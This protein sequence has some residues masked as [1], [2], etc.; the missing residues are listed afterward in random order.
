LSDIAITTTTN[1][2]IPIEKGLDFILNHFSGNMLWPKTISTKATQGRQIIVNSRE[3]ALAYFKAANFFDCRISA[4]PYW[5]PSVVS[6]FVSVKNSIVPDLIM[7]DLDISNFDYDYKALKAALQKILKRIKDLLDL[8]TPIVIWSGN[9]YHIYILID[10]PVVLEDIKEFADIQQPSTKFLRFAEWYL[11]GGLSDFAHNSTVSLNNCMLRIPGSYN[12]KN[13]Q[14]VRIV[15]EWN[16]NYKP[17]ISLLLGSFCTYLKDQKI[18]EKMQKEV[19]SRRQ[20]QH[21]HQ[22]DASSIS[23]IETLLQNAICEG[24][25]MCIWHI[26]APYL[27]NVK[28]K[29]YQESF[30]VIKCW[31]DKCNQLR[32]LDFNTRQRIR[33]GLDRVGNYGPARLDKLK[34]EHPGLYGELV[35]IGASKITS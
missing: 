5:R 32:R 30:D 8:K 3:E 2:T 29:S 27:T 31:L 13:M 15:K 21:H 25:K 35:R 26:L 34:T 12:S 33:D 9:G 18:K 23:W 1:A 10:A 24:R 7:I 20:Q 11:S 4:Y 16:N 6:E 19:S 28:H 14:V 22:V 17:S